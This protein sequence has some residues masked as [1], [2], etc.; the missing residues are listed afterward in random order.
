MSNDL[1]TTMRAL[2]IREG[3]LVLSQ[4]PLPI[5]GAGEILIRVAYAGVN[6]AD[7]MQMEG[8][9]APPEGASPLPGLE[10]SGWIAAIGDNV[11]GFTVGQ[12]VCALLSGG[13]YAEYVT[14]PASLALPLPEGIDL[15]TAASIPEAAATSIMALIREGRLKRGERVLIHGG[16]SGVGLIIGQ[17]ARSYDAEVF[18][19]VGSA[20]K[21]EFVAAL[22]VMPLNYRTRP[23]HEQVMAATRNEGVDLIIDTLGG[24]QL[25]NHLR[26]L[27]RGGR[28]VTLAMLEGSEIPAGTKMTRLMMNHVQWSGATLRSRSYAEKAEYMRIVFSHVWPKLV[29]PDPL[30][31][32]IK[33]IIDGV[34]ALADAQKALNRMQERLHMGKILLEVTPK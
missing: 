17:I 9:Y 30:T 21:A 19:T 10:V 25:A 2:E 3:A 12:E 34:F 16:S 27:R 26:C 8:N 31:G 18:A 14:T 6:R 11:N 32:G 13:G 33:P 1:P 5:A 4:L 23:F 24:P 28:I 7:L 22:G 20:Q 29:W 15:K